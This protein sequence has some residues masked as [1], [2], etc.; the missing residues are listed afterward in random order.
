MARVK[1]VTA[2]CKETH[3]RRRARQTAH[4]KRVR[5]AMA[6]QV[7]K[8]PKKP[9]TKRRPRA[10]TSRDHMMRGRVVDGELTGLAVYV[11]KARRLVQADRTPFAWSKEARA[12]IEGRAGRDVGG[13]LHYMTVA[14][15]AWM[16]QK[17]FCDVIASQFDMTATIGSSRSYKGIIDLL[18]AGP[19]GR[20][21]ILEIKSASC[22]IATMTHRM[23]QGD[24]YCKQWM[25]QTSMYKK[26]YSGTYRPCD[27]WLVV[28]CDQGNGSSSV[29][30]VRV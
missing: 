24:V 13:P 21:T 2:H 3:G 26:M 9:G 27:A 19:N 18:V 1:S 7:Q 12:Y 17:G 22:S 15:L 25:Q 10:M 11:S 28:A 4:E 29:Y 20:D 8:A 5:V 16:Q 6:K 23:Q 30:A 14:I